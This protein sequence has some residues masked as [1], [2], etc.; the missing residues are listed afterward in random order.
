MS[1]RCH[2]AWCH[3]VSLFT[4]FTHEKGLAISAARHTRMVGRLV[5][6]GPSQGGGHAVVAWRPTCRAGGMRTPLRPPRASLESTRGGSGRTPEWGRTSAG[7][8][9]LRTGESRKKRYTEIKDLTNPA[10]QPRMSS[11]A[12]QLSYWADP[13]TRPIPAEPTHRDR[14]N[15]SCRFIIDI[16]GRSPAFPVTPPHMRVRIR[17]F[18]GLSYGRTVNLGIPNESK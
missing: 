2:H 6:S 9:S 5:R 4:V 3:S 17:R 11:S 16:G 1:P 14:S 12:Q 8:S 18:G 15:G 7:K 13:G 10:Q